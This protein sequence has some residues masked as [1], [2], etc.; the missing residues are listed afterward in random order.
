MP[1]LPKPVRTVAKRLGLSR[2]HGTIKYP[3][4]NFA[5]GLQ[6]GAWLLFGLVETLRPDVCVEIGSARGLSACFV[7]LALKHQK[8]GKLY[9]IDPHEPTAWND[10]ASVDTYA[11]MR[12]NLRACGVDGYVEIVRSYSGDAA[13]GWTRPIDMIFIDGDHSYDGVRRDWDLF[14]PFV[15][16]FGVVIFHDT[17]W[18]V[19]EPSAKRADM[20]VPRFVDELRRRGYPVLTLDRHHGISLVQP[21]IGGME[22][23]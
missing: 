22:L 23:A 15:R 7:G 21:K 17:M 12:K 4:I 9:A 20:G 13:K 1:T 2:P 6:D 18:D 3:R 8:H 5:S 11:V 10:E 14:I 19:A 16:D